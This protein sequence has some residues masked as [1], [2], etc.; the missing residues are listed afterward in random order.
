[1]SLAVALT[2]IAAILAFAAALALSDVLALARRA[3]GAVRGA[4]RDLS[5]KA[6]TDD[7]KAVIARRASLRLF[8]LAGAI[9]LRVGLVLLA[10]AVPILAADAAGLARSDAV[11]AW[12][13]RLDVMAGAT[14]G[15]VALL[16]VW[17]RAARSAG[18]GPR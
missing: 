18:A 15:L 16:W 8:G 11:S 1:M 7:E 10:A 9:A 14:L 6:R 2:G 13:L 4:L 17:R 5:D 12:L 3:L